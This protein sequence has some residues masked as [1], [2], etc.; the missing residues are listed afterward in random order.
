MWRLETFKNES[1]SNEC[2]NQDLPLEVAGSGVKRERERAAYLLCRSSSASQILWWKFPAAPELSHHHI[3]LP[4]VIA[5][6][7]F[8][9]L[10]ELVAHPLR[11]SLHALAFLLNVVFGIKCGW[12]VGVGGFE[13]GGGGLGGGGHGRVSSTL[14]Q[15]KHSKLQ[16]CPWVHLSECRCRRWEW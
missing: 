8:A 12:R 14:W 1:S 15:L 6:A 2:M 11:T 13:G 5:P 16:L 4:F 3:L 10:S 9:T 7:A